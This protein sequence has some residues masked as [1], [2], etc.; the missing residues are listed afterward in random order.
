MRACLVAIAMV[1]AG[2]ACKPHDLASPPTPNHPAPAPAVVVDPALLR[3]LAV[4][5]TRHEPSASELATTARAFASGQLTIDSYIDRLVA[6][7]EFAEEVAPLAVLRQYLTLEADGLPVGKALSHVDGPPPLYFLGAK[8]CATTDAVRV[9]PWWD[10]ASEVL[11]CR[12]AYR[13]DQWADA[14]VP[15]LGLPATVCYSAVGAADRK[16][17]V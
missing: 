5:T 17:V 7:N 8:P 11:V 6:S 2:A 13:P 1:L 16:S 14:S 4:L 9:H 3:T 10:L 12:D 15:T